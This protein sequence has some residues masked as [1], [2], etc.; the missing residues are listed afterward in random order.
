MQ[1]AG[2]PDILEFVGDGEFVGR[3]SLLGRFG[4]VLERARSGHPQ[5]VVVEGP[6]GIGK[7]ALVGR[8]LDGADVGC[9]LRAS[10]DEDETGL[11][12]GVFEQLR[13]G[14]EGRGPAVEGGAGQVAG[15]AGGG[16]FVDPLTAGAAL[17]DRLGE[18]QRSGVVAVVVD[19]AQWAD[20]LSL[21]A[22]A[23]ALRRLRVDRVLAILVVREAA[24]P[25]LPAGLRRLVTFG[26]VERVRLAG[27]DAG[28][29][30]DLGRRLGVGS[31]SA[32]GAA[33]LHAH[34]EG[35][36]LH[37]RALLEQLPLT[38]FDEAVAPLPA[39][40]PFAML[41]LAKLAAC[42]PDVEGLVAAASVLGMH[43]QVRLAGAVAGLDEPLP[44]LDQ[45]V[46]AGLLEEGLNG[47]DVT[48]PHPL[49]QAAVYRQLGPA[50][51]VELHLRAAQ[52]LAQDA[53][54][55]ALR[56]RAR[57]ATGP[58]AAL[59]DEL[60]RHG[61]ANAGRGGWVSAAEQ[62][63]AAARLAPH[64][65][66]RERFA[67][68]A[69]E[70][71]LLAGEVADPARLVARVRAFA[72]TA[73]RSYVLARLALN[74][75]EF[76]ECEALL[77][78]AWQRCDQEAQ[79]A[80]GARVAGHLAALYGNE[81]RGDEQ[82]RWADIALR[83][84]PDQTATDMIRYLRHSGAG[85]IRR[86]AADD[87]ALDLLPEPALATPGELEDLLGRGMR[88]LHRDE[89]DLALRDFGGVRAVS[90][91]RSATFR[92]IVAYHLGTAE[93]RAGRWDD[94]AGRGEL[95]LSIAADADEE[96]LALACRHLATLV[97]ANRGDWQAAEDHL[98]VLEAAAV[99]DNVLPVVH[100]AFSRAQLARARGEYRAAASVLEPLARP[101]F[102]H[103]VENP[104]VAW[105]IAPVVDFFELTGEFGPFADVLAALEQSGA[106]NGSHTA[107]SVVQTAHAA[108]AVAKGDEA[109]A[110]GHF[111][112]ALAHAARVDA[113]F[114]LALVRY[115]HG[116]F[117]R[118]R[119]RRA[120]AG[121]Q[122][123]PARDTFAHLGARP[124]LERCERELAA[125]GLAP[126]REPGREAAV[127]TSQ[128]AVVARLVATGLT[129]RQVARELVVS[130]K[131]V[132]Y[133][134]GNVFTK[135][136]V[137][138]RTQL[139]ARLRS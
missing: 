35:N 40:R 120:L 118:R 84:A 20:L 42:P 54:A 78:D 116:R 50:R 131:T 33:R 132:E 130:V 93:F 46:A 38:A 45:A 18:L 139:A 112:A 73:W 113:P 126:G 91:G 101:R 79:P 14:G 7:T 37:A 13:A 68:E 62:L 125:C 53:P 70:C 15:L 66:D 52:H 22:L 59:S 25:R 107:L 108:V 2:R 95:A 103:V 57:A 136:D 109:T 10:G 16:V 110:R 119:G 3:G 90:H 19:D 30:R 24:D 127:L 82:T 56:H 121:A 55:V 115:G 64:S 67:L 97:P 11:E 76:G 9:V 51:R 60:A 92:W 23:F 4:Q 12:Y 17:L 85:P 75:G 48:F 74:A 1:D 43:T 39:P 87:A 111:E 114:E 36:P 58:D 32:H 31:L 88:H 96:V 134:L 29:L 41:V 81:M 44:A 21:R 27:L 104:A 94:A 106:D 61:R 63:D 28:E 102:R 86:S 65:A 71:Q 83:L 26:T 5:V 77:R 49:V 138:S 8:F 124:F 69:V 89:L 100:T 105:L 129:N 80:L 133:H 135:L 128:E 72:P 117:L 98:R 123:S 122:L 137:S 6:A 99:G 34:T 47:R